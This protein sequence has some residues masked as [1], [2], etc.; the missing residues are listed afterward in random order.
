MNDVSSVRN[1][2]PPPPHP[3]NP[4]HPQNTFQEVLPQKKLQKIIRYS[5]TT[6]PGKKRPIGEDPHNNSNHQD[7][8]HPNPSKNIQP[9]LGLTTGRGQTAPQSLHQLT[10]KY[11]G[12]GRTTGT[13]G[14]CFAPSACLDGEE[15]A[16]HPNRAKRSVT[17]RKHHRHIMKVSTQQG[18]PTAPPNHTLQRRGKCHH[19]DRHSQKSGWWTV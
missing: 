17:R 3:H 15:V 18:A 19:W 10:P 4:P 11:T 2:T 9:I 7:G 14:R 6:F 5:E 1:C 13:H 8:G 16:A 12:Q